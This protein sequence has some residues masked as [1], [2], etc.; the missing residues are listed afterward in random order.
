MYYINMMMNKL[1]G[2]RAQVIVEIIAERDR[3]VWRAAIH[4]DGDELPLELEGIRFCCEEATI[5]LALKA[6][7]TQCLL[8][9]M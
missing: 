7:D 8:H 6:L 4:S 3:L 2:H 5:D 9:L 1:F